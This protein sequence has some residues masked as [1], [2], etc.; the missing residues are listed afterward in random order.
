VEAQYASTQRTVNDCQPPFRLL[1]RAQLSSQGS[2]PARRQKHSTANQSQVCE[3]AHTKG[4]CAQAKAQ[5]SKSKP[6][7]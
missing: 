3:E 1:H 5:H 7:L 2:I 6:S 4:P